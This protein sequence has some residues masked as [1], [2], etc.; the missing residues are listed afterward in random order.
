MAGLFGIE[1][2]HKVDIRITLF[3]SA[4]ESNVAVEQRDLMDQRVWI[5]DQNKEKGTA[6]AGAGHSAPTRLWEIGSPS[7]NRN[8]TFSF[9][10]WSTLLK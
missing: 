5:M 8:A 6:G 9:R 1:L 10:F 7:S 4:D 2:N 3:R